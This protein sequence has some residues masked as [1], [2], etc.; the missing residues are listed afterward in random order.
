MKRLSMETSTFFRNLWLPGKALTVVGIVLAAT[1]PVM[2]LY[3]QQPAVQ[4]GQGG[5]GSGNMAAMFGAV[6]AIQKVADNLYV[7][8]GGGGN[9][10]VYIVSKGVVL[11]DTKIAGQGQALLDQIRTVTQKPIIYIINTHSHM[12]HT[13]SNAFFPEAVE[14][15]GHENLAA[16]LKKDPA[17]QTAEARRG[18]AEVTYKDKLTLMSGDDTIE[19]Y[20][21]GP[22]HTSGDSLV[23]FRKV[24]AMASGDVFPGKGQPII[25]TANGG[26]GLNYGEFIAKAAAAIKDVEIVIPGHSGVSTWQDFVDFGEFNRL[27][28]AHARES[29]KAGKTPEQAKDDFKIP[30]KFAGYTIGPTMVNRSPAGNFDTMYKELQAQQ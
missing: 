6:G 9:S 28:L 2:A 24:R 3:A 26:S 5:L 8:P 7:I 13:G 27:M 23:V 19:L 17:F 16:Q 11:V 22:A 20:N 14:I 4:P 12:D 30:Q 18:L 21:F 29:L 15:V 1:V 25:D 10:T